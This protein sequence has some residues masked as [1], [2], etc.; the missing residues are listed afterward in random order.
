MAAGACQLFLSY[1]REDS[2][3]AS[4]LQYAL[5]RLLTDCDVR[6]WTYERDQ[7][8]DQRH[9]AGGLKQAVRDSR[10]MVLLASPATVA[11]GAAQWMELAYADAYDVPTFILLHRLTHEQLRQERV[12]PLLIASQCNAAADWKSVVDTI[13]VRL[14]SPA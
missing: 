14:A 7:P 6:V 4:L 12:P 5:E 10:A 8:H 11:G 13:R 3:E 1:S 9:I 2:F